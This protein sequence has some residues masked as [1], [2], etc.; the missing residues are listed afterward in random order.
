MVETLLLLAG[1]T[2]ALQSIVLASSLFQ[3]IPEEEEKRGVQQPAAPILVLPDGQ[4]T[5]ASN[6]ARPSS[7]RPTLLADG[8]CQQSEEQVLQKP[9]TDGSFNT[10][11]EEDHPYPCLQS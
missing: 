7:A 10:A 11:A 2:L 9:L 5:L 4:G 8:S 3:K 1:G 6:W